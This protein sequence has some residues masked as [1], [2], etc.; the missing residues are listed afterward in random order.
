[1]S[2]LCESLWTGSVSALLAGERVQVAPGPPE[3]SQ[4][5]SVVQSMANAKG[6]HQCSVAEV[7]L[8]TW[9]TV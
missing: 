8:Q 5:R 1:M 4:R 7:I 3:V 9:G 6:S 2:E